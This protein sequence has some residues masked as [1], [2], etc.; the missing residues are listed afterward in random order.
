MFC[1]YCGKEINKNLETC[2]K[3]IEV[4]LNEIST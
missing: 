4:L 1:N 2:T 3:K